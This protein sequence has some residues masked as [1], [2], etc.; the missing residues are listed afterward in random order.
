MHVLLVEPEYYTTYPPLGLLKLSAFHKGRGDTTELVRGCTEA[1][2]EPDR[3]YVTSL[4][5]WAW[6]PVWEAVRYYKRRFPKAEVWLGGLY[7]SLMPEHAAL[8]G[9]DR[10][11]VGLFREAEDLLPDYS[12]VPDWDGSIVFSSRGCN[13]SCP[14][15]AVPVLEGRLNSV[16]HSIRHL[17][18]PGHSRVIFWDNN[19]L[20]SPGWRSIFEELKDL[21]LKVDFNQGLDARLNNGGGGV[22]ARRA[23]ARLRQ[24]DQGQAGLR[25]ERIRTARPQ[26]H[27]ATELGGDRGA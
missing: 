13:R 3:I 8:S 24:G 15:C 9:A 20:Q 1:E 10:V 25:P 23:Q 4:Y 2:R 11:H 22:E 19:I 14:F 7:A 12:L 27:R 26:S 21:D 16:K 5:T 17:I 6:K 18:Y